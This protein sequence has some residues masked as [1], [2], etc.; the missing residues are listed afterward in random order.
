MVFL[1]TTLFEIHENLPE[2]IIKYRRIEVD[3]SGKSSYRGD[4]LINLIGDII[5]NVIGIYLALTLG[6][7]ITTI[8]LIIL[9]LVITNVVGLSYWVEFLEFI[10]L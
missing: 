5:G 10:D 2:Q 8:I 1:F 9:F 6:N 3:S 7:S 4:S